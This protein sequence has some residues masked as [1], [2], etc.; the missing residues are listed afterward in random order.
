MTIA[1]IGIGYGHPRVIAGG[2]SVTVGAAWV[3]I[4][5]QQQ[6]IMRDVNLLKQLRPQI[7]ES[8]QVSEFRQDISNHLQTIQQTQQAITQ[9]LFPDP[10][11]KI[12]E[13][14][15]QFHDLAGQQLNI[16]KVTEKDVQNAL[17]QLL[18][19]ELRRYQSGEPDIRREYPVPQTYSHGC[20]I[21]FL[22]V[23][24]GCAIEVKQVRAKSQ[25]EIV[26]D[27]AID[28]EVYRNASHRFHTLICFIYDPECKLINPAGLINDLSGDRGGFQVR[29]VISPYGATN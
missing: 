3:S 4:Q 15:Q 1:T 5:R 10:I 20:F 16:E 18:R 29:T 12:I 17:E 14:C 25:K 21:D 13:I 19:R 26:K 24:C 2:L 9:K 11:S 23:G 27:L 8:Q 22:L 7:E 6:V 28:F